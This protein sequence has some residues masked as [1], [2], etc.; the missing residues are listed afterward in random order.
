MISVKLLADTVPHL[1]LR[2]GA[3]RCDSLSANA[4]LCL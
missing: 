3:Y 4:L 2:A 1:S